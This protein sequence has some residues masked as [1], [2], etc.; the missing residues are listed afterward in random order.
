MPLRRETPIP[1][2]HHFIRAT[3]FENPMTDAT[4]LNRWNT[5]FSTEDYVFGREPNA[6]LASQRERFKPGQKALAIADGEGRN[7][8]WLAS[9][10][11]D[12]V[13]VDFS[14][15]ASAKARKLA[16]EAGVDLEII[17]AD[18]DEW[19]WGPQRFDA[20]V[21]IF[22][23]FASPPMRTRIFRRMQEVLKPG[24]LV[25]IEGYRTEQL[26]YKT[27]GPSAAEN[28][29]TSALLR[30]AFADLKILHLAEYDA[31]VAEGSRHQGMSAL[32]DL[33]AQK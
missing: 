24:G 1:G 22:F 30:E 13:S 27:G 18:L 12:V 31:E 7:G 4:E 10:G 16:Q 17:C 6:F 5:R 2:P 20:V 8:V 33:V 14:P 25:L 9:L 3:S 28:L 23:Q 11:L 29:Y 15:I 26:A 32:I 21:G 19:D